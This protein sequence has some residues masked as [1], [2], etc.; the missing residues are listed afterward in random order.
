[1][2]VRPVICARWVVEKRGVSVSVRLRSS[3][4]GDCPK[5]SLQ[6]GPPLA[7][8]LQGPTVGATCVGAGD[9][10]PVVSSSPWTPAAASSGLG[11]A[12]SLPIVPSGLEAVPPMGALS[13]ERRSAL[14]EV[15]CPDLVLRF[16]AGIEIFGLETM[17]SKDDEDSMCGRAGP[18]TKDERRPNRSS[19][20]EPKSESKGEKMEGTRR[21]P[22]D[23]EPLGR[24]RSPDSTGELGSP[25]ASGRL[26][27]R[28]L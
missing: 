17:A 9:N 8:A 12:V 3:A 14:A 4:K 1:M 11:S 24:E 2:N 13:E 19:S 5:M 23:D 16:A 10:G 7:A 27:S 20:S 28:L 15:S 6:S 25:A 21:G 18:S 26:W 22:S